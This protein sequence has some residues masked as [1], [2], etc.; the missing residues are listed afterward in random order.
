[1]IG[2]AQRGLGVGLAEPVLG[3]D[4]RGAEPIRAQEEQHGVWEGV[5]GEVCP[6]FRGWSCL[7]PREGK[8]TA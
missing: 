2:A 6:I 5:E 4:W 8:A 3:G 1:V 7:D